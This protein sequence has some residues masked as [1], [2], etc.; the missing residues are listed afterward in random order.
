MSA[1]CF[2]VSLVILLAF[3]SPFLVAAENY[4]QFNGVLDGDAETL[5]GQPLLSVS[6]AGKQGYLHVRD[7]HIYSGGDRLRLLGVNI[8][9][10]GAFPTHEEADSIAR[11]LS[12]LGFNAV[13]F[14]HI[15]T[16][17]SPSGVFDKDLKSFDEAQ[18]DKFDYFFNALRNSGI[19]VDLN[20]HVGRNYPGFAPWMGPK[21]DAQPMAWKGVDQ[22]FP[23]MI[24]AQKEYARALL[25]HV[26]PYSGHRYVD[27]PA[28]GIV[29]INNENGLIN[30]WRRGDLDLM[31]S[32]YVDELE[33]QWNIWLQNKYRNDDAR[34]AAWSTASQP[35]G[36]DIFSRAV[37]ASP[38]DWRLQTLDK[39][40]AVLKE[41]GPDVKTLH[42]SNV[43]FEQWHIQLHRG[44]LSLAADRLYT[45]KLRLKAN[46]PRSVRVA[47]MQAHAPWRSLWETR[48][49]VD[50]QWREYVLTFSSPV[51]ENDARLTFSDLGVEGDEV[52][53][54]DSRFFAGGEFK[55]SL[56]RKGTAAS[57]PVFLS[58]EVGSKPLAAQRDWVNFL[59]DTESRYWDSMRFFLKNEL[60]V[61][62]LIVGT[63]LNFS[64]FE[65]QSKFDLFD[66]HAYW[67]HPSFP[68]AA[69][70]L[71]NWVISNR[72][73]AG[74]D[75]GGALSRLGLMRVPKRPFIVTEYNHTAPNEYAAEALPLLAS[76]AA[77]QDWDGV[78]VYS[79][80]INS[81]ALGWKDQVVGNYFDIYANPPKLIGSVVAAN[82]FRRGDLRVSAPLEAKP[83]PQRSAF[84]EA[85]RSANKNFFPTGEQFGVD[86]NSFFRRST[87]IS[88]PVLGEKLHPPIESD[89]KEL[90]WGVD[91][92]AL[93]AINGERTKGLVGERLGAL[94][95]LS[96]V[97]FQLLDSETGSGVVI[98]T[99]R[100][101]GHFLDAGRILVTALGNIKNIGQEWNDSHVS[102]RNN[103]GHGPVLV[104]GVR[105]RVVFP[106]P[107][108]RAKAWAL[109]QNGRRSREIGLVEDGGQTVL[110]IG[111][112]Y[113]TILYEIDI[114][115]TN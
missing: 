51:S 97:G 10:R 65:V 67:D 94:R 46:R 69:W 71:S 38:S 100:D 75:G 13:R 11:R 60:G 107:K 34:D 66:A 27:E 64:P 74:V 108:H 99:R 77:M 93:V 32:P 87:S 82:I 112:E 58:N 29:E 3:A 17:P 89:T 111:P 52:S 53:I 26:N 43:G 59:W 70:S 2:R 86:K 63:Q 96:G 48:I 68:G 92:K 9:F 25:H 23:G 115:P 102:I 61:K 5:G 12:R 91:K 54:A 84:I 88:G 106:L 105:A 113:R 50:S 28:L 79:Y 41:S 85:L 101:D 24:S 4:F 45:L 15:D 109:D 30:S 90:V 1:F 56:K 31:N 37:S 95:Y 44:P 42:I 39:A 16:L 6:P 22:F 55:L 98:A 110:D 76:Y 7:G 104:E 36:T 8:V 103:W 114:L 21:G 62:S 19:F 40:K 47:A 73:M 57:V 33:R 14:H 35:L 80:G 78:F 18:L 49:D 20:L 83:L 81:R 72:P